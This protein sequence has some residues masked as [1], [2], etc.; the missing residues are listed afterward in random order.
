MVLCM[1]LVGGLT[2]AAVALWSDMGCGSRCYNFLEEHHQF[3]I[4][5]VLVVLIVLLGLYLLDFFVPPHLPGMY[6]TLSGSSKTWGRLMF[7]LA[8]LA[9]LAAGFLSAKNAPPI[10]LV[11]TIFLSPVSVLLLRWATMP[12]ERF[13]RRPS[14]VVD[15]DKFEERMA[16]L[17]ML[18]GEEKDQKEFYLAA[19]C[20]FATVGLATLVVWIPWAAAREAKAQGDFEDAANY[21]QRSMVFVRWSAPLLAAVSNLIFTCFAGLRVTLHRAYTATDEAKNRLIVGTNSSMNKEMM[22]HRI[23]ALQAQL[24]GANTTPTT[25]LRTTEDRMQQYLVQ[26]ISHMKQLSNM[27]KSIGCAFIAMIGAFYVAFQ[28]TAADSH[29][30]VM[31]QGALAALFVTFLAWVFVSFNRLWMHTSVWLVDLPLW[32]AAL[33]NSQANWARAGMLCIM[34]PFTPLVVVFS[35]VNQRVRRCRRLSTE[36]LCLTERVQSWI[37]SMREWNWV[38]VL[39][40]CYGIAL[41]AI[42]YKIIPI[43]LNVLLAWMTALMDSLSFLWLLVAV[44]GCGMF[45]FMLPPIPGPPIYLF[46][47]VMISDKC[48]WGFWWGSL[49]CIA[50]CFALKLT[51]CAV[52][53]KLI[54]ERLG[55]SLW[56]RQTCRVHKPFMRAIEAVLR[57]PGLSFGKVMILCGGPDWPTSVLAGILKLSL[58]QCLLGTCPVLASV[59]PLALTGSFYL[60]R[61]ESEVWVRSGNLM[62]SLTALVSIV[63][64]AGSAWA[65]QDEFDRN[66]VALTAPLIE[67][68]DLEWLDYRAAHI[69]SL[70]QV[71]WTDLPVFVKIPFVLG[72]FCVM[73][74]AHLF[75]WR[76]SVCFGTFALTDDIYALRWLGKDG[77]VRPLG[78]LGL[79]ATAVCFLGLLVFLCWRKCRNRERIRTGAR[80]MDAKEA[81]WKRQR[82]EQAFEAVTSPRTPR[83]P[84]HSLGSSSNLIA[85][86]E[87]FFHTSVS[88][89]DDEGSVEVGDA[90]INHGSSQATEAVRKATELEPD[91]EEMLGPNLF[92]DKEGLGTPGTIRPD[93][94]A[95][96]DGPVLEADEQR[97]CSTACGLSPP[98]LRT[99]SSKFS[100]VGTTAQQGERCSFSL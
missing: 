46:G 11:I 73:I 42:L 26:H 28:L 84:I 90:S 5:C 65:I 56:V 37:V 6:L 89:L 36:R 17:K 54:G 57:R 88:V 96:D 99:R 43:F 19:M 49:V 14:D 95:V 72:A 79:E 38:S 67:H 93:S 68:V 39:L 24:Q 23:A 62:F 55:N 30:A 34:L 16:I 70:C 41:L 77:L 69:A 74:L 47:G 75:F 15:T 61:Q 64:W 63:F 87:P 53:Q 83:T 29:I 86:T 3:V 9:S 58:A 2:F 97:C 78:L 85:P 45:L 76:G 80:E 13:S 92:S 50:L 35:W 44:F 98:G 4:Y 1:I 66:Y 82:T 21:E 40:W 22:A 71:V 81:S 32:K 100:P 20:A 51:A 48:P 8:V 59:I 10:P 25:A 91:L 52:Q 31:V 12:Q 7:C 94:R 60:R 33:A 27:V 18:T